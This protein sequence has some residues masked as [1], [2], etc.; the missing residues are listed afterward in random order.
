MYFIYSFLSYYPTCGGGRHGCSLWRDLTVNIPSQLRFWD[1]VLTY[2]LVWTFF[3]REQRRHEHAP[4]A[5][6]FIAYSLVG[7]PAYALPSNFAERLRLHD[8]AQALEDDVS[9]AQTKESR[10]AQE[11]ASS[12]ATVIYGG[13]AVISIL[14]WLPNIGST[15][16]NYLEFYS[17]YC[18]KF[19]AQALLLV[20]TALGT[21]IIALSDI[22][23][24]RVI[25]LM[26]P[27][28]SV[29][30]GFALFLF[31]RETCRHVIEPVEAVHGHAPSAEGL[32][33]A[34]R[35]AGDASASANSASMVPN[36]TVAVSKTPRKGTLAAG[37][38][39]PAARNR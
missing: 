14:V 4:N 24:M 35:A 39:T 17:N 7:S 11:D 19:V 15:V 38:A 23:L 29:S 16:P 28:F 5:W 22:S 3:L 8:D 37:R 25:F 9:S 30:T 21:R 1:Y 32:A 33:A 2:V 10:K 27:V 26:I 18:N 13:I 34:P 6:Q 12:F 36:S 20:W 31:S